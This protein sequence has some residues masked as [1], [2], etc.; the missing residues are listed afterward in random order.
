LIAGTSAAQS[1][2]NNAG[3]NTVS[4]PQ[5]L[6]YSSKLVAGV[7]TISSGT[8]AGS[9]PGNSAAVAAGTVLAC[10]SGLTATDKYGDGCLANEIALTAPRYAIA[11]S[12]QNIFLSDYTNGLVRRID[13]T[14]GVITAVAGG[15]TASPSAGSTTCGGTSIDARGDGCLSTKVHLT[16][17]EGLAFATNGDLIFADS[18]QYDVRRIAA[19]PAVPPA[20]VGLVPATG[21]I[22]S[23]IAGYAAGTATRGYSSGVVAATAS[24]LYAPYGIATDLN[25]NIFI[26]EEGKNA[27][28][29]V[30]TNATGTNTV[31]NIAVPAGQIVKIVGAY[32]TSTTTTP[33]ATCP[34]GSSGTYGCSYNPYVDP[35]T[36]N[37]TWLN[38]PYGVTV[39][40]NGVVYIANE[41]DNVVPSVSTGGTL[42]TYAGNQLS[43]TGGTNVGLRNTAGA[44][45][46]F[47][48]DFG[49]ASDTLGNIYI[50]DALNG[51]IWRVDA[52]SKE[53]YIVAGGIGDTGGA[54]AICST[55]AGA[56]DVYGDGCTGLQSK[57]GQSSSGKGY[58]LT[59]NSA[60]IW[61]VTVDQY[62]DL[63]VGDTITGL[64]RQVASGAYFGVIGANQPT[65]TILVHYVAGDGQAASNPY[66]ISQG[67]SNFAVGTLP[68]NN[69]TTNSD[70]TMDCQVPIQATPSVLGPFTGMLTVKST[71]GATSNFTLGGIY[72]Q[73]PKTRLAVTYADTTTICAGTTTHATTDS[74]LLTATIVAN[75]PNPPSGTITFSANGTPVGSPQMVVNI[76]TVAN[77]VYGA[78]LSNVFS[79]P[80][81]YTFSAVYSGD[82][83]APIYFTGSS[84]TAAATLT[85]ATPTFSLAPTTNGT[86][87]TINGCLAGEIGQCT[88]TAGQTALY[89]V[90]LTETVYAGTITFSCSGAP[91]NSTCVVAP[92]SLTA[93]GC[94][95]T[96]TL[97]VS[98]LTSGGV[99]AQTAI[100][101]SG[102]G[103][104]Q[105][106][107]MA[108]GIGLALMIGLRRRKLPLRGLWMVLALLLAGSGLVGCTSGTVNNL[109]VTP[110]GTYTITVTATGST[111]TTSSVALPL[112]IQ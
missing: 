20:T 54:A 81:T 105:L 92:T 102:S 101:L 59:G 95:T 66:T 50:T 112:T 79:T 49:V 9:T 88:V 65:Q 21:G 46:P 37:D 93:T 52:G 25:G 61:G 2:G 85:T 84:G 47:G 15:A 90:T 36:A 48:S 78:T 98:V 107:S 18:G 5:L 35:F 51:V 39:T 103:P 74:I 108:F 16:N 8:T 96:G 72:A 30:N 69:C 23:N 100:G 6:P 99:P 57:F 44:S 32:G 53:Q 94:S 62:G 70:N 111:G 41:Y 26:A 82:T 34:N 31:N 83:A 22:I 89:S 87:T 56:T 40:P 1:G 75:G 64:I 33:S 4:G 106:L 10:P 11:D 77:P 24:Y 104:W 27:I 12:Q 17:P 45:L 19:A 110:K 76:G 42:A 3:G 68:A 28:M 43:A 55:T 60:G 29:V 38:S 14:T 86:T 7:V 109:P 91:A 13:A 58:S 63:I 80:N 73:S 71:L 67:A 97:A